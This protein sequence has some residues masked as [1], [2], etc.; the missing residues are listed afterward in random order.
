MYF[1]HAGHD[2]VTEV[3][4]GTSFGLPFVIGLILI[5]VAAIVVVSV[6]YDMVAKRKPKK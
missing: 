1:S 5:G 3:A 4:S 6:L 2:H